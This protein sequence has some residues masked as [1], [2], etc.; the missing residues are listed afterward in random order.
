MDA[1]V[2]G[3][4]S[5]VATA[6]SS[7]TAGTTLVVQAGDGAKFPQTGSFDVVLC[8]VGQLPLFF[9]TNKNAEICR[10]TVS[11]D[12]LTLVRAQYGTTAMSV[13]VG[14]AVD[15]AVTANLLSQLVAVSSASYA[16]KNAVI[17]GGMDIW[18][19]G[20][21]FVS[22][23][24]TAYTADRWQIDS[25]DTN[26]T[27][28]RVASGLTGFQ[29][30][31]R[32][33]RNSGST[34]TAVA[35]LA[36]SIETINSVPFAGQTVTLSFRVRAGANY[37]PTSSNLSVHFSYGTGTDQG[38]LSGFTGQADLVNNGI[39]LTTSWQTFTF[40][41]AVPATATELGFWVQEFATGTAGTNDYFDITGVQLE[42]GSV[43]TP[44]SRAGG[45][46]GGEL[47]LCQRYYYQESSGA[48]V[49][50]ASSSNQTATSAS[51]IVN[52]PVT[53]RAV[54]S[55]TSAPA[56]QFSIISGGA[57]FAASALA[58]GTASTY[59][60]SITVTMATATAGQAGYLES[61]STTASFLAFSA[62]L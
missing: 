58:L 29:Y 12:T 19:R 36:Q 24:G 16:G 9:G 14:W 55:F 21:S 15:N 45:S 62:E 32:Y 61:N 43:A 51:V 46:I 39:T 5:T 31:L 40:T 54:P 47:A 25:G 57:A 42:L 3:G 49:S 10:A 48:A 7:P 41:V 17:N 18:Q 38:V 33:Q 28:S 6:P 8:P 52:F 30:A 59:N 1:L 27:I 34:S 13:A 53:M 50:Y 20:T 56:T 11:T 4:Y 37:S 44:F 2:N 26:W 60:A 23:A 35:A 22:M